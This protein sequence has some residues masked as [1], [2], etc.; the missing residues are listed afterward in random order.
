MSDQNV[1]VSKER[2]TTLADLKAKIAA[3]PMPSEFEGDIIRHEQARAEAWRAAYQWLRQ[4][5]V[6]TSGVRPPG[7]AEGIRLIERLK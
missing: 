5:D 2:L 7:H 1:T 6:Y 4:Y 3:I